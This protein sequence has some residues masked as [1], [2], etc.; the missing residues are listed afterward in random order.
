[1][2]KFLKAAVFVLVFSGIAHAYIDPFVNPLDV[3]EIVEWRKAQ[4]EKE[5]L[6]KVMK[7]VEK[8][9]IF[10]L[11]MPPID[12]LILEGVIGSGSSLKAVA[13]DP[14]TGKV[15]LISPGDVVDVNAKVLKIYPDRLVLKVYKKKG[16]KLISSIVTINFNLEEGK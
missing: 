15:Y 9:K 8:P 14:Q 4:E 11:K 13:A 1:M 3:R 12:R 10:R 16:G 6:K 5:S 2:R 7:V